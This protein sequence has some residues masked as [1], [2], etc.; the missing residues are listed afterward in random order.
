MS[1]ERSRRSSS[2]GQSA[3]RHVVFWVG[4]RCLAIPIEAVRE[5]VDFSRVTPVPMAPPAVIGIV[6]LRGTI[7]SVLDAEHLFSGR[8]T[9]SSISRVLVLVRNNVVVSGMAVDKI[10]GVVA[11]PDTEFLRNH[12]VSKEPFVLGHHDIGIGDLVAVLDAT[13]L[14]NHVESQRSA[15]STE[16]ALPFA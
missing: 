11:M 7:L 15:G 13:G 14:F 16:R 2:D 12:T 3:E 4:P 8:R 9:Q 5:V 1:S 10:H 6:S